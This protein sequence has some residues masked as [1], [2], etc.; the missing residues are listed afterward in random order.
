M[1]QQ[2]G[3]VVSVGGAAAYIDYCGKAQLPHAA[4][5]CVTS[6]KRPVCSSPKLSYSRSSVN[7]TS[8]IKHRQTGSQCS[9]RH[10]QRLLVAYYRKIFAS[11]FQ[12][13][14]FSLPMF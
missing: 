13:V 4:S 6:L 12:V 2:Q 7:L 3:C 10:D 1:A 14:L 8:N 11:H 9:L 5:R